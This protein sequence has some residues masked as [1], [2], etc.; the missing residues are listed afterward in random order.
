MIR[1][2]NKENDGN[3]GK[4][5]VNERRITSVGATMSDLDLEL[6]VRSME[7]LLAAVAVKYLGG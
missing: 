7:F 2:K 4:E 5:R 3:G 1:A 6:P